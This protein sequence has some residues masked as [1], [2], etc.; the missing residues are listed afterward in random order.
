LIL[1]HCIAPP[2]RAGWCAVLFRDAQS[3]QDSCNEPFNQQWL[4]AMTNSRHRLELQK[5]LKRLPLLVG[6]IGAVIENLDNWALSLVK[7][8]LKRSYAKPRQG[9]Q[10]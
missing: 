9:M 7:F 1:P 3:S 2:K 6:Q 10:F 5:Q 8:S 4:N